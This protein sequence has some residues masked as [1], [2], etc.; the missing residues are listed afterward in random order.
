MSRLVILTVGK[1]HSGKT[2]FARKLEEKLR[3]SVVI[4]QDNHAEF[5]NIYYRSLLPAEGP[6][7]LKYAISQ[8][9]LNYA[10][11][12]TT[13]HVILSN[14]NRHQKG[15]TN[16]LKY[17]RAKGLKPILVNFKIDDEILQMR[18]SESKRS[19]KIFR[20][21]STFEEVLAKQN[22]EVVKEPNEEEA[23]HLFTIHK[24]DDVD[25]VISEIIKISQN[26]KGGTDN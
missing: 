3:G 19:T 14:S 1:T 15:R 13:Y 11:D 8:T 17:F 6:N 7:T 18:V 12:Q 20:S 10:V 26:E 22:K 21:A 25:G 23:D 4:D 2:T 16:I 9:I 5:I 24:Q